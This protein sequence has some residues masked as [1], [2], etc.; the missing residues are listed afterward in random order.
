MSIQENNPE[1]PTYIKNNQDLLKDISA[2]DIK[3]G[4]ISQKNKTVNNF[5]NF[6]L[7][8]NESIKHY[9]EKL[10]PK[11][12][13]EDKLDKPP[14]NC[15]QQLESFVLFT[16][17]ATE[18]KDRFLLNAWLIQDNSVE[19][20]SEFQSLLSSNEQQQGTLC[21]LSEIPAK[22]CSFIQKGLR[23]LRGKRY[24]LVV[25][26]FLP[27]HLMLTEVDRWQM[28]VAGIESIALGTK[29]PVRM[30]SLG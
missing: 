12:P 30:R 17:N 28:L 4:N 5:F 15:L 8:D 3:T 2:N 9:T 1:N 24:S 16:L 14:N 11:E 19:D 29:Y 22:T 18:N 25:E 20:I 27:S 10:S 7:S 23:E 6:F 13:Q 26:F 21:K